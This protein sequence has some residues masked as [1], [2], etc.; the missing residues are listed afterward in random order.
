MREGRHSL[1]SEF[2]MDVMA[3][4]VNGLLTISRDSLVACALRIDEASARSARGC[5]VLG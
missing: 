3:V 1:D 4:G 5:N 2:R